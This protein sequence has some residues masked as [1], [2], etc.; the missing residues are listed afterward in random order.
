M[1]DQILAAWSIVSAAARRH[2][3]GGVIL[4]EDRPGLYT[5]VARVTGA[6]V[7]TVRA[8]VEGRA[9]G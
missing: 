9:D 3:P 7:E 5:R 2:L 6:T 4:P 8:E 1:T